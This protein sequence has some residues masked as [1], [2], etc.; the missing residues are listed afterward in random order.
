MLFNLNWKKLKSDFSSSFS[1]S[2]RLYIATGFA[3]LLI[4]STILYFGP[5]DGLRNFGFIGM[6]RNTEGK[7]YADSPNCVGFCDTFDGAPTAPLAFNL[8]PDYAKFDVQLHQRDHMNDVFDSM[9]AD[10][11]ADCSAPPATHEEHMAATGVFNCKNHIMTAI[12]GAGYGMIAL[13]PNQMINFADGTA[14][15]SWRMSTNRNSDRDWLEF[16]ITPW[17]NNITLPIQT[18]FD[19]VDLQGPPNNPF[20]GIQML[21]AGTNNVSWDLLVPNSSGTSTTYQTY[22]NWRSVL[23]PSKVTRDLFTLE[24]SKTHI[25]FYMP[26]KNFVIFDKELATPLPFTSGVVQFT[27]HSYNPI[28][29][30][31]LDNC[32]PS[33]QANH[34]YAVGDIVKPTSGTELRNYQVTTAGTSGTTQPTWPTTLGTS[35]TQ[36]GVTYQAV[37]Y[38]AAATTWHWDDIMMSPTIPFTIIHATP[39]FLGLNQKTGGTATVT[40]DAPS[41]VGSY[42]RFSATGTIS[43]SYDNGATWNVVTPNKTIHKIE[44]ASGYFVPIPQGLTSVQVKVA[45]PSGYWGYALGAR[46]FA[47][48][49][50]YVIGGT[51]TPTEAPSATL[52]PSDTPTTAPTATPTDTPTPTNAP[53]ATPVNSSPVTLQQQTVSGPLWGSKTPAVTFSSKPADGDV[54]ILTYKNSQATAS[55]AR[56]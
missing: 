39:E 41:P 8:M 13:T 24:I 15:I 14:T 27:Q 16:Y 22:S 20:V 38:S 56:T 26:E 36:D 31:C 7:N 2:K 10:H 25:K 35:V 55:T 42:L 28:K 43:L 34:A 6:Q 5:L 44:D 52:A 1:K 47:V 33:W 4:F 54:I 23:T 50:Q 37:S 53:T 19:N 49:S 30:I 32:Y 40:F 51:P 9:Q 11:G 3:L 21:G 29:G 17:A 46:D 45:P 48:W 12:S 18:G